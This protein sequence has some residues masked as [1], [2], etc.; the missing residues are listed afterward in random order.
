MAYNQIS[1]YD[2]KKPGLQTNT[3]LFTQLLWSSTTSMGV[4]LTMARKYDLLT[5]TDYM[6]AFVVIKYSPAGNQ[7][8]T[9]DFI[10]N[11]KNLKDL[12]KPPPNSIDFSKL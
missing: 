5:K 4:G 3:T 12:K 7:G 1:Y 8:T 11:V 9:N 6:C 10:K 2:W